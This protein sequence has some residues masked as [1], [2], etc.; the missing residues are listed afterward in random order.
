MPYIG[1]DTLPIWRTWALS[2]HGCWNDLGEMDQWQT[3]VTVI[4]C[5]HQESALPGLL[6]HALKEYF[7][8]SLY[9]RIL[10]GFPC[11]RS[12]PRE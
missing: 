4:L 10:E 3:A 2:Y 6:G 5:V 11:W 9:V 7:D 8:Q 12:E 1:R